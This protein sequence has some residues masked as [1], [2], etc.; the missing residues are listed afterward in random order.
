MVAV[1]PLVEHRV[2][3]P[4]VEGSSP[5]SH[6]VCGAGSDGAGP[7]PSAGPTLSAGR[8]LKDGRVVVAELPG[9]TAPSKPRPRLFSRSMIVSA[10]VPLAPDLTLTDA[11][12]RSI[13]LLELFV[14]LAVTL[15]P[16]CPGRVP[17]RSTTE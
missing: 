8:A 15:M 17:Q 16:T 2:V 4:G 7:T 1:A 10:W 6:P 14:I 11:S 5:F 12:V 3:V 9:G 13:R